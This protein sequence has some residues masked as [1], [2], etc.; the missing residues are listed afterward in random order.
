MTHAPS[1][2]RDQFCDLV[3]ALDW[4]AIPAELLAVAGQLWTCTDVLPSEVCADLDMTRGSSYA[5]AAR[6]IRGHHRRTA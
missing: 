6:Q 1:H 4:R 2:L 5:M 3:Q